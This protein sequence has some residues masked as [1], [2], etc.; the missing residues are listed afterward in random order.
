MLL[1]S[2]CCS[3]TTYWFQSRLPRGAQATIAT[4]MSVSAA[5]GVTATSLLNFVVS[6]GATMVATCFTSSDDESDKPATLYY[7]EGTARMCTH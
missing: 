2:S 1:P 7:A 4:I 5:E 6:D 3:P